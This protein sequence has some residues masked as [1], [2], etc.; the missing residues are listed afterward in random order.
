M[1]KI[2]ISSQKRM[3]QFYR[4]CIEN[5]QILLKKVRIDIGREAMQK[6]YYSDFPYWNLLFF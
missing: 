3:G 6:N 4:L 1:K 5:E 2:P